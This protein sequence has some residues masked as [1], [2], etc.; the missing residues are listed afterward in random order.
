MAELEPGHPDELRE[1]LA[2]W[3]AEGIYEWNREKD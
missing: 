3:L 2:N 1:Q